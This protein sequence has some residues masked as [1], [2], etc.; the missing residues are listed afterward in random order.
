M[1]DA[2][3]FFPGSVDSF[4]VNE[5]LLQ[6]SAREDQVRISRLKLESPDYGGDLQARVRF[7]ESWPLELSGEWRVAD[8]GIGDLHGSLKAGGNLDTLTVS[9]GTRAPA[10]ARVEGQLTDLLGSCT[11]RPL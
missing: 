3:I 11:G 8:P 2:D 6:V 10:V 7:S 1:H 9:V 5:L 4:P